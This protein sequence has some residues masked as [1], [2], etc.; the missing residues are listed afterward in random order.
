MKEINEKT[1]STEEEL[2]KLR[3]R[4]EYFAVRTKLKAEHDLEQ[5]DKRRMVLDLRMYYIHEYLHKLANRII[6]HIDLFA[7][8]YPEKIITEV[9][10]FLELAEELAKTHNRKLVRKFARMAK[11]IDAQLG[12]Y[13]RFLASHVKRLNKKRT[14]FDRIADFFNGEEIPFGASVVD[15]MIVPFS[16]AD[17]CGEIKIPRD[18][19]TVKDEE[20]PHINDPSDG[21]L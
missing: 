11:R 15:G 5:Y 21:W 8:A 1:K 14:V 12:N 17:Y 6:D 2:K 3:E 19:E 13:S 16:Q 4:A 10:P 20:R 7:S 9:S 18:S